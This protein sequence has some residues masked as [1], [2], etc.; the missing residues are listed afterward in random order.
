LP[1]P[2]DCKLVWPDEREAKTDG[3]DRT[4]HDYAKEIDYWEKALAE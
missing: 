1:F 4:I 2:E 3:S